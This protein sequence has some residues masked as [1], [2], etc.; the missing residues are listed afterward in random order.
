MSR[1][2]SRLR[3]LL[4]VVLLTLLLAGA[5]QARSGGITGDEAEGGTDVATTGCTCHT[6][7]AITP[8]NSVTLILDG[9]PYHWVAGS[10]YELT[11]QLIGGPSMDTSSNTGGF[12][13]RVSAGELSAAAGFESL[14][15]NG[16]DATTLTH[17]ASG[18]QTTD[19]SWKVIWTAPVEGS[20][21]VDI[22]LAGNSVDGNQAPMAP[23]SWNRLSLPL[24]EGEDDGRTRTVF[25]G[26]GN[27]AAPEAH[28]GELDLHHM[29]AKF[30][31]HWL[32]LLG[33]A[34]VISVILFCGFF[35]RF[36]FS[37]HYEGRSNLLKL[38]IKHLRRG[39]QV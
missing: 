30:R 27:I 9:V 34:A 7:N 24:G 22:W 13:M 26:D 5:S 31:A 3:P 8:S 38:R 19:R 15:Q 32:G 25:A 17:T 1:L 36:G 2:P 14:V 33:F 11:I 37:R 10:A 35:L 23:D 20:G 12:S 28:S 39:D 18:A 29:G 4:A 21:E 16:D 6:N